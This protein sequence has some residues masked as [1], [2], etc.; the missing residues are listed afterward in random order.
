[1]IDLKDK[2]YI[3]LKSGRKVPRYHCYCSRCSIS[4][5]YKDKNKANN[6]CHKCANQEIANRVHKGKIL[7]T[8]TRQRQRDAAIKRY[9]DPKWQPKVTRVQDNRNRKYTTY[10]TPIQRKLKHNIK[11]LLTVKLKAHNFKKEYK[12]TVEL[13]GYTIE[14]LKRHLE[15][16]FQ[17]GMTWENYGLKGWH[18][19]H[20]TPDSW[21]YYESTND[22]QFKIAWSLS[23][24]QP[25]WAKDN[26]KK[27]NRYTN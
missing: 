19:D 4:R 13:L 11:T 14:E 18:I 25:L 5:G 12:T 8:T 10:S 21:F 16:Q 26:L 9:H 20:K 15:S 22:E 24:L 6:L 17:E 7:S 3:L 23:N 1:M 2:T 27:G